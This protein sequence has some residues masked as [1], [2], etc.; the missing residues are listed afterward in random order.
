MPNQ[1][2]MIKVQDVRF[3]YDPEQ[4]KYAVD[5]VSLDIRRG[6][7]V[8]VLGAN[9]CGKS[10]LAKHFN[11]IL[12]PEAG[13]VLVEGMD[14][15]NEDHLYDVRQKVGMVFQNP[16]N[17]IVA[18]IVEEDVAFAPENLGVPPEEIRTRIDEAMKLAGIYE[19]REA[20]P[21]KLSG[22]Q[23]QRVA[24]AGVIAMRPDCL[25]M[26]ESTAMLDPHGRA[27]VMKTIRQLRAAGITIVSI[28]HYME[29][30]AQ[31]DRVL[32]MSRGRIV[33]EGTP[34]QVF[35]QTERLHG[36]HL[37]VPQAA[38][39]RDELVKAGIPMPEKG[40]ACRGIPFMGNRR[41]AAPHQSAGGAA[42]SF[43][44]GGSHSDEKLP[45]MPERHRNR[46]VSG[47]KG[48]T[49][50]EIIRVENL[51]Y[52]YNQ[53]MPDATKALDDVSFTVE[54]GD[55][56][57]II[58]ST[59]SGKSTLIS[60]F[61]GLNRPTSGRV[62]V[63]GRD[64]WEQGADLRSFRFLVGLVMQYPEYQLF[65]ETCARDIAYGPRNM[66][67]DEAE[68]QR[69][70]REAAAFVGLSDELLEKSPFELS[71]GQ[72]RR[73]AIAGV[74]AMHPRVLVLDEPAAGL[75]P[76]GRDTILSQIRDY[77]EKTG[78]TVLLVSHSMEDIAKYANRVLV[79]HRAKIAMY[80][81][82]ENVFARAQELLELGLSVPQVTQIF[83]K[84]RQMGLDIP[85]DVYTIPY[86]VKTI[87]KALAARQ[88]GGANA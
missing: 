62:L 47:G 11:A 48:T 27:Q 36:Y 15:R 52:I 88:G 41:E 69:R 30:A 23:K 26:D 58:G 34:E 74:M 7:F 59:G 4:P 86:A 77:H 37:D 55:F 50:S 14:T 78:I 79:M 35:S 19:K 20:A 63:D 45:R 73:V 6:E 24:I 25:V 84:L 32:V 80:D 76:E 60:H 12:L 51:S 9:G 70:V 82:V 1:E 49:M 53:G 22:G 61:N 3:R 17:Q 71:G 68:V 75:D 38:E 13:T 43:P 56:V 65:E 40:R 81:T 83:L 21:Y 67:L 29:E 42:D 66:G 5:G 8:A 72:K 39:L 31:A 16:D 57:G 44:L 10:T 46:A 87:Q 54:E 64:L 18:T 33:M 2:P 85:A 28:T